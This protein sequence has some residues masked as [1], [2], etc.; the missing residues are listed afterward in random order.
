MHWGVGCCQI[1]DIF[2]LFFVVREVELKFSKGN[3]SRARI[4]KRLRSPGIDSKESIP[5]AYLAWRANTSRRVLYVPAYQAGDR[6]LGSLKG[7]KIWALV[8]NALRPRS[9]QEAD[10]RPEKAAEE[11]EEDQAPET[12]IDVEVP[13]IK[14]DLGMSHNRTLCLRHL[15]TFLKGCGS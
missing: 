3:I 6:F 4:F 10:R 14:T 2:L 13:K 11:E 7:L 5:P 15:F 1:V 9:I 12:R 8:Y